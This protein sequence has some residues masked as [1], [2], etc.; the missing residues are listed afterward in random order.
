MEKLSSLDEFRAAARSG[1]ALPASIQRL[2][3]GQPTE[4]DGKVRTLRFCFSDDSVDR[5]GD[6]IK[7]GGW[8]I[9]A[10]QKNPVALWAHDSWSPPVGR[11]SNVGP[12][13][14]RLMGDIEFADADTY[15][16]ADTVFRLYKGGFL[17]AVSVG[18]NPLEWTFVNDKDRPYGIDFVRQEL[19]EI[20]PCP[21]PCNP[22][23]LHEARAKGIDTR[24]LKVWAEKILDGEGTLIV[25]RSMIEEI[26]KATNT[27]HSA[28]AK[29]RDLIER[30]DDGET[31]DAQ[32]VVA[33]VG[34]CGRTEDEQ[35]GMSDPAECSIHAPKPEVGDDEEAI[36]IAAKAKALA[37]ATKAG[38][39]LS[40]TNEKDLRAAVDYHE[41]AMDAH[42]KAADLIKGV[43]ARHDAAEDDP[44]EQDDPAEDQAAN[45]DKTTARE[46]ALATL[47]AARAS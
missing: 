9:S 12:E 8:D 20:S 25:P 4:V 35:C 27:P 37:A 2:A 26:F 23:A 28:R 18:F 32:P 31:A 14:K 10:F 45:P 38:R 29:Y 6:S 21:V 1:A 5:A 22:N 7:V 36:K 33:P 46:R 3:T 15:D 43:L 11:A 44:D 24:P 16:F 39:M 30:K 41:K 34:N 17:N 19:L 47:S 13:G 42:Q 40:Q